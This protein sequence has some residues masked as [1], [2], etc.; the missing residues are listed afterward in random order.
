M[1]P[2]THLHA[3]Q[4]AVHVETVAV[5]KTYTSFTIPIQ[6]LTGGSSTTSNLSGSS[7]YNFFPTGSSQGQGQGQT[8]STNTIME[9]ILSTTIPTFIL[10]TLVGFTGPWLFGWMW[11]I[12]S[13]LLEGINRFTVKPVL[14]MVGLSK[15]G[16]ASGKRILGGGVGEGEEG[17]EGEEEGGEGVKGSGFGGESK[18]GGRSGKVSSLAFDYGLD[19][20]LLN[21]TLESYWL[22]M[23]LWTHDNMSFKSACENLARKVVHGAIPKNGRVLDFGT[24]CGDQLI[25]FA[26]MEPT[27][28][29]SAVTAEKPQAQLAAL[30][31]R[32]ANLD[33]R[34]VVYHGDA[35]NPST[36]KW[37]KSPVSSSGIKKE[38]KPKIGT[39]VAA[40]GG[41]T[42]EGQHVTEEKVTVKSDDHEEPSDTTISTKS[43]SKAINDRPT[44]LSPSLMRLDSGTF[45][46]VI[47]LDSCYHY[48][49]RRTFLKLA[50]NM[51]KPSTGTLA[52]SDIILA[53]N[54][55]SSRRSY[56]NYAKLR[57]FCIMAG[58]PWENLV[59][60]Q[61]YIDSI[62]HAG[63]DKDSIQCD[64]ISD[65]VFPGL[66]RFIEE[67]EVRMMGLVSEGKMSKYRFLKWF[68]KW[69]YEEKVLM[70]VVVRARRGD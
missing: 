57:A 47:S 43:P 15:S 52:I 48:R 14:R 13:R 45:D 30:R 23:G 65:N 37:I 60:Q 55:V 9:T 31:V 63:F 5:E 19:H 44:P 34:V 25:Y 7:F 4:P 40:Y 51:L 61:E 36:W 24:G 6:R 3:D 28:V 21:M 32:E 64:D 33:H 59:S 12:L 26:K 54:G 39:T 50:H 41:K 70:F 67:Q 69:V 22:N 8:S 1:D 49:S 46:I 42:I 68:V 56:S 35:V 11:Y 16:G 10:G 58:V 27:S 66:V 53:E 2:N 29:I 62:S 18:G 20:A 17:E 38:T